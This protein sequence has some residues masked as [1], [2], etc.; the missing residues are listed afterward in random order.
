[1]EFI[2]PL[3]GRWLITQSF[4]EH[5]QRAKQNGWCPGPGNCPGKVY[6]YPALD[7]ACDVGTPLYATMD[8][9]IEIRREQTGYGYHIRQTNGIW[10]VIYGHMS[11][12]SVS[13]GDKVKAGDQIGLTG[14]TG[15]SSGP[16]LHFEIRKNGVPVDPAPLLSGIVPPDP[17]VVTPPN[18]PQ[19]EFTVPVLPKIPMVEV[20]VDG[21]LNIRT[22]PGTTGRPVGQLFM[23]MAVPFIATQKNGDDLWLQ[24]GYAQWIAAKYQGEVYVKP[25]ASYY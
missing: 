16:H 25:L 23:G 14:N 7:V 2:K 4:Q 19:E 8:G 18:P 20:I 9:K 3:R 10:T 6:Y 12:F 22:Q 15:N 11:G 21:P 24:I 17:P 13:N 5:L 1:M